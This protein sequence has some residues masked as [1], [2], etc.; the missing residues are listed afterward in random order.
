[1]PA[2][3]PYESV[4]RRLNKTKV[5]YV[6]IGV[7]GINY[8]VNDPGDLFSTQD[9][10]VLIKP[11]PKN[12]LLALKALESDGFKLETNRE[13][14]GPVDLWL[15]KR[16]V[17]QAATINARK[18]GL[19]IDIVCSAGKIPYKDWFKTK[20]NFHIGKM[21]IPVGGLT[22]LLRAKENS[23]REKDRI[24]LK[25]YKVKLKDLLGRERKL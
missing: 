15:A 21:R 9:C 7:S 10:D 17:E 22:Q 14:I 16:M 4:L 20:R 3:N 11:E 2:L 13:P 5:N 12:L 19:R 25:L 6:L 24:F 18:E 1:M 23:D 8:Y